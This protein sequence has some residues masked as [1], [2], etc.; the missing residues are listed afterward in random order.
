MKSMLPQK[1]EPVTRKYLVFKTI[2][3]HSN[4]EKITLQITYNN[5]INKSFKNP[6]A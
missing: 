1:E 3:R 5:S 4:K 6:N 2:I